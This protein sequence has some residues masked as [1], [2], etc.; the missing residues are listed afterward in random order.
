M[1]L[2]SS[3]RARRGIVQCGSFEL[4]GAVIESAS[5][6]PYQEYMI[7]HIFRGGRPV[8]LTGFW[9]DIAM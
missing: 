1:P 7:R 4:T 6:E 5:H 9:D 3:R 8:G 2:K